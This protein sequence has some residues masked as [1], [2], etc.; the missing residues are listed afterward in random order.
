[1][2]G[3]PRWQ[4]LLL[5]DDVVQ[6][7]HCDEPLSFA[8]RLLT[9]LRVLRLAHKMRD[10]IAIG[11]LNLTAVLAYHALPVGEVFHVVWIFVILDE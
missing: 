4:H 11:L 1:M 5:D 9:Q 10:L 2:N 6:P 7:P 3:L 8:Q